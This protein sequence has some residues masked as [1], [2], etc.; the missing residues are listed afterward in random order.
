MK[1]LGLVIIA[2]GIIYLIYSILFKNKV[3]IYNRKDYII[4][5]DEQR[6]LKLQLNI[7]IINSACT[8]LFGLIVYIYNFS[9][10][11]IILYPLAFHFINYLTLLIGKKRQYIN[12]K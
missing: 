2:V 12:Y 10:P 5:L 1:N 9:N 8:I 11:I 3:S 6:F 4:I 7:S